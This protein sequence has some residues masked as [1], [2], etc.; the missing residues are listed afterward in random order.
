MASNNTTILDIC[1]EQFQKDNQFDLSGSDAFEVFV[2]AQLTNFSEL[3][4]DDLTS[5]IVDGGQDGGIDTF[6][7]LLDD[8]PINA[9]DDIDTDSIK[10]SS[11]I[12]L[13]IIQ[14]KI[15]KT[16]K[17]AALDK[18]IVSTPIIFDL[19][20]EISDLL[21]RF[22]EALVERILTFR[23]IWK[24]AIAKKAK[25]KVTFAYAC[26]SNEVEVSAVFEDKQQ[27]LVNVASE[28]LLGAEV[29]VELHSAKEL[30]TRYQK[31]KP[32]Q[33]V[34]RCKETPVSMQ[35]QGDQVGYI[36][37]VGLNDYFAFLVD[38]EKNLREEIFESN[39]RHYQGEVDVNKAIQ[40][41]LIEDH[42]NDFWWLNNGITVIASD[43][44]QLSKDLTLDNVQIVNGLQTSY[45][46]GKHYKSDKED[47]RSVL[48]KVVKTTDKETTDK[49]ISATNRQN[50]VSASVLRATDDLQR[51][52]EVFFE[53]HSYYYDRRKNFY[54]NQGK[55]AARIFSIQLA[56]QAIH[57][58]LNHEPAAARSKPTSLI[59]DNK[60]YGTIFKDSTPFEAI[61]N[62]CLIVQIV[63]SFVR[64][65]LSGNDKAI[66]RNFSFHLAL[67]VVTAAIGNAHYSASDLASVD[68]TKFDKSLIQ[69]AFRRL[70]S[71]IQTYQ[72]ANADE[73]II[74]ISKSQK[75]VD[76]LTSSL[77]VSPK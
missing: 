2:A 61:L 29:N 64:E 12:H 17:E 40:T 63:S 26:K 66:G 16:F 51:S 73:N 31:S 3:S 47:L 1:I 77:R 59:K 11:T 33:L 67:V 36:C 9:E 13:F 19:D 44:R 74:N 55:P 10:A 8:N 49:I 23:L 72:I 38:D 28:K 41:T 39:V 57:A 52:I 14:S 56:A 18:L 76:E 32:T 68:L 60:S 27:Q 46:I 22:N 6:L 30:F 42:A 58:I 71:L 5:S 7:I 62:S 65:N 53:N 24:M 70:V 54:K 75:F 48:V 35:Y 20:R 43:V 45:T 69:K 21:Q 4:Y 15:E 34:L 37:L 50:P 25:L